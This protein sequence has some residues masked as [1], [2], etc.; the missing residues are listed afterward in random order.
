MIIGGPEQQMEVMREYWRIRYLNRFF[1]FF[2]E[3][4]E[5]DMELSVAN[6][7]SYCIPGVL[8]S[9]EREMGLCDAIYEVCQIDDSHEDFK[10]SEQYQRVAA[11]YEQ[12][13]YKEAFFTA[14]RTLFERLNKEGG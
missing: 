3:V 11:C 1:E 5:N 7:A 6:I 8:N 12:A 10:D 14:A 9:I 4:V 13:K 2:K